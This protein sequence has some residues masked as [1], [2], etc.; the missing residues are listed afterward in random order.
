MMPM[1]NYCLKQI[2]Q[3]RFLSN[4]SVRTRI[5]VPA[6]RLKDKIKYV[7]FNQLKWEMRDCLNPLFSSH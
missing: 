4:F 7:K 3:H 5:L 6:F 2:K 1:Q